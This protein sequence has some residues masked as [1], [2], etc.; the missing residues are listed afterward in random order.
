MLFVDM[1][2]SIVALDD[3]FEFDGKSHMSRP[4]V[5]LRHGVRPAL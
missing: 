5:K 4:Y 2:L 1:R 3:V